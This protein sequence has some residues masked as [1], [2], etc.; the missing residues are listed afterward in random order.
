MNHPS[1]VLWIFIVISVIA[2]YKCNML[3]NGDFEIYNLTKCA[4][5]L[6]DGTT[7]CA[8]E[9]PSDPNCWYTK[10]NGSMEV[11]TQSYMLSNTKNVELADFSDRLYTLCQSVV[12]AID[13]NYT[14]SLRVMKPQPTNSATGVLYLNSVKVANATTSDYK[15][16]AKITYNF[17]A[18]TSSY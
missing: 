8:A 12:L 2:Q 13:H 15:V 4:K 5:S 6:V 16:A 9:I 18:T 14:L 3:C 1:S 10:P 17:T 7:I 11:Q